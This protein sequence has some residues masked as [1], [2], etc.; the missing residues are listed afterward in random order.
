MNK[1]DVLENSMKK[2]KVADVR[3][4]DTVRV[5][6]KIREGNKSR[7]QVFEGLVIRYRKV[8]SLAA[9]ITVRKITSGVGVEKSWFVHSPNV[10]KIE[11]MKRSKVR[12]AF[13]TYMRARQGKSA[14]MA[15]AEFDKAATNQADGRTPQQIAAEEQAKIAKEEE[16]LDGDAAAKDDALNQA[17][18][19]EIDTE[20][21]K[22]DKAAAKEDTS[23]SQDDV[24][25]SAPK[26]EKQALE[27][28]ESIAPADEVQEGLDKAAKKTK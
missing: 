28:D 12:R 11:V 15:E 18:T 8:N 4:G 10:E 19:E 9:Y 26:E 17:D 25:A 20:V 27:D 5:H 14:R 2:A 22:E 6:Q 3:V 24:P 7:I 1:I 23:A 13:L 16:K 21:K